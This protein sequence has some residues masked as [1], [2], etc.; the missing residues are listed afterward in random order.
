MT[1]LIQEIK[2]NYAKETANRREWIEVMLAQASALYEARRMH[3]TNKALGAWLKLNDCDFYSDHDR[4]AYIKLGGFERARALLEESKS[5]SVRL[6]VRD[7]LPAF[8]ARLGN[9]AKTDENGGNEP[10]TSDATQ[11]NAP[12]KPRKP[13]KPRTAEPAPEPVNSSN[14]PP[15]PAPEPVNSSNP[16]PE[17]APE[18]VNSSNPPPEP[19][20]KKRTKRAPDDPKSRKRPPTTLTFEYVDADFTTL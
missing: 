20:P 9:A 6:I 16:L 4:A 11:A 7:E 17:P 14:P 1:D 10:K 13:R 5:F 3:P 19:A 18:P 2:D 8:V 15:E 12:K